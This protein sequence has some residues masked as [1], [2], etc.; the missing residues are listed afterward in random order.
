VNPLLKLVFASPPRCLTQFSYDRMS[1]RVYLISHASWDP[2]SLNSVPDN[3][4]GGVAF[5][6]STSAHRHIFPPAEPY[7]GFISESR[8]VFV[9]S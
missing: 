4:A 6:S 8:G 1:G 5:Q 3:D 9:L 7:A 2:Y